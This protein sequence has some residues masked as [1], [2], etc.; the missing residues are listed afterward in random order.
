MCYF[1]SIV[2]LPLGEATLIQNMNPVFATLLAAVILEERVRAPEILCLVASL[3]GVLFVAHPG[4]AVRRQPVRRDP[5][6]IAC[7]VFGAMCS[8]AAYT[9]VRKMR[10]TE[11]P[12]VIVFYL[13]LLSVP[14]SL[15]FALAELALA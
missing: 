1:Y 4:R 8:G 10:G 15:P 3:V 12:L 11:H 6:A 5:I 2:H 14:I 9:L 13:P 7:A